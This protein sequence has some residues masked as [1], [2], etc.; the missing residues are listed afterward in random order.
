MIKT[1]TVFRGVRDVAYELFERLGDLIQDIKDRIEKSEKRMLKLFQIV[2]F[3]IY[4]FTPRNDWEWLA[5]T[6]H[7]GVRTRL[8][9]WSRNAWLQ[10]IFAVEKEGTTDSEIYTHGGARSAR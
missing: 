8:I 7:H 1:L 10:H 4:I 6:Q 2:Q 3:R 9:D 5:L